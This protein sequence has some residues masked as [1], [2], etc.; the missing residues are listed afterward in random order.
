MPRGRPPAITKPK[1][2]RIAELIWLAY[3]DKQI[4]ALVD[5]SYKTIA[6]ARNGELCPRIKKLALELEEPYRRKLWEGQYLPAGVCWMLER[7]Y[8]NEFA[9]PEIQLSFQNNYTQNNLSIHITSS[10][11]KQIE[12]QAAPIR[13]SVKKMFDAYRPEL[14]GNG[15]GDT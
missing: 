10:E 2:A 11:A 8:P 6:R 3:T 15:N 5:V 7:R 4:A 9:K 14:P 1:E 12:A 13:E